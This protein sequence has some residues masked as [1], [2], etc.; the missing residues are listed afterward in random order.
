MIILEGK[1][2]KPTL[3]VIDNDKVTLEDAGDLW[4]KGAHE[5]EKLLQERF[6]HEYEHLVIGPAGENLVSMSCINSDYYR[7]AGRGG[8]GAVMGSKNVKAVSIRGTGPVNVANVKSLVEKVLRYQQ[9]D[10]HQDDNNFIFDCGTT[11]FLEACQ[12][13]GILPKR[14]FSDATDDNWTNYNGEVLLE[15]LVGKKRLWK[16]RTGMWKLCEMG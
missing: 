8:I 12:D 1:A 16:L 13:G 3:I 14:N 15:K 4:G 5:A 2:A 11:A 9:E 10:V 6:G 7:Q